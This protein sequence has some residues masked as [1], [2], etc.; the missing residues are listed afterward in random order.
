MVVYVHWGVERSDMPE[1]YQKDMGRG[2]IDAGAD[3]V[4]GSHPHVLQGFEWYNGGLIAYSLGNF[5]FND[6][7]KDTAALEVTI[8]PGG[9]L[10][11]RVLPYEIINRAV[12]PITDTARLEAMRAYLSEISFGAALNEEFE[13]ELDDY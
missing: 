13:I 8:D 12:S 3:I 6:R 11:A 1:Q 9:D 4:I 2:Y 5:I 10:S 7:E